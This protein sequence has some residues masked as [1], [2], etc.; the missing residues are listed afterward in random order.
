M[1]V[2]QHVIS[3]ENDQARLQTSRLAPAIFTIELDYNNG[4]N[5][6]E[7]QGWIQSKNEKN[8]DHQ[9]EFGEDQSI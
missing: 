7:D 8:I 4:V 2:C 9:S 1:K 6:R 5:F 3:K